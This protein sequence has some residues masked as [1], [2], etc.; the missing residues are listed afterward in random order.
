MKNLYLILPTL[1]L[2][3]LGSCSMEVTTSKYSIKENTSEYNID[4]SETFIDCK[5]MNDYRLIE[6]V[7]EKMGQIV[8]SLIY[9]I[10]ME[11]INYFSI[12]ANKKAN[13]RKVKK[14]SFTYELVTRDT[15]F[16]ANKN[17]ISSR[18]M[19]YSF[20]G[21]AHGVTRFYSVNY[22]P[23]DTRFLSIG[24]ILNLKMSDYIDKA[25]ENNFKNDNDCF[26]VKP[27]L[28]M[29]SIVNISKNSIIFTYEHYLLGAYSCGYAT[30][31][32]PINE[33]KNALLI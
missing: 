17:I 28:E 19:A 23:K 25:I 6:P 18:I 14:E 20:L 3:T 16:I 9:N 24:D 27:T 5:K 32:V 33:I 15:V 10:K 2:F 31:E 21:G 4:V 26:N 8:D 30:I 29:V 1:C 22:S 13:G 11:A 7:N 12:S